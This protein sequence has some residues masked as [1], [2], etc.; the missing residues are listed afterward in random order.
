MRVAIDARLEPGLRG[1]VEP[2]IQGL[3][4]GLSQLSGDDRF[5][6]LVYDDAD[7]WLAPFV[8][9]PCSLIPCQQPSAKLRADDLPRSLLPLVSL[10]K[11]V[12]RIWRRLAAEIPP[13]PDAVAAFNPDVVHLALQTGFRTARPSVFHPHDLQ[14]IHHP[15]NFSRDDLRKRRYV[16]AELARQ[17]RVVV[18]L[19]SWGAADITKHLGIPTE[20]IAVVPWAPPPSMTSASWESGAAATLGIASPYA[21]YPAQAWPHKNHGRLFEAWSLLARGPAQGLHLVCTGRLSANARDLLALRDRL[22]LSLSVHFTGH[23]PSERLAGLWR[24]ARMLVYPSL[25]EGWGIPLAEAFSLGVPATCASA[26]CLPE[27]AGDAALLFD[28]LNPRAIADAVERLHGDETER[29]RLIAAGRARAA[30]WNW[31][32]TARRMRNVYQR[33]LS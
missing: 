8:S 18:A 29:H 24:E 32:E 16:Y 11:G 1:G 22:G 31:P 25:F 21:L 3:A 12:R 15:G 14:H 30:A 20:R 6:F 33:A 4:Y 26:S 23:L 19:S 13:E 7:A 5:G 9:G 10:A 17:A 2:V 27:V 28:P